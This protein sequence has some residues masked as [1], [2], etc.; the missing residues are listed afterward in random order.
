MAA[1]RYDCES[2]ACGAAVAAAFGTDPPDN[3]YRP[4]PP[5][6]EL[7]PEAVAAERRLAFEVTRRHLLEL[8]GGG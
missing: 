8:H 1:G 4:P 7:P 6:A 3:P 2:A 5:P